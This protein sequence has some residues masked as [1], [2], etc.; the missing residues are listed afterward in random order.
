VI[1]VL[2]LALVAALAAAAAPP[3]ILLIVSD[4][5]G[6][7]DLGCCGRPELETPNLDR[8]IAEG[9]RATSFY[10]AWP[11]CTPSRGALLTGRYPQRNGLY[12][13]IR[14]DVADFG[15]T[16]TDAEYAVTPERILGLDVRETLI[17]EVLKKAGYATGVVGKWDSGQ[18]LRYLPLQRGFDFYYGFANTG[19]DYWTHERYEYP[20][21]RRGNDRIQEEG[22]ITDLFEREAVRFVDEH[23]DEPFFLYLPFNAPHGASNFDKPGAQGKPEDVAHYFAKQTVE[24]DT[25]A[26]YLAA[27]TAMDRA[28]GS[29]LER[30]ESHGILDETLI[31]FFSDNGG[32]G[33][34]DNTP[35]RGKKAQMWEGGLRVPFAA[36]WPEKI[37]AGRVTDEFLTALEVFPTLTA[38]AGAEL[39]EG[40]VYDGFDMLSVLAGDEPSSREEM[41]WERRGDRALRYR[42]WK[43]VDSRLGSGLFDLSVDIS[44]SNDLSDEMPERLR[45][46]QARFHD[47]KAR[48]EAAEPRGPFR[49]Y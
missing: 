15:V 43:W 46:M 44:E 21:L 20:S 33:R 39:P 42:Q 11:A 38:A 24:T 30:L 19:V 40:I 7:A 49:D 22:Y 32:S 26:H 27:I 5:Q 17:S 10:V 16:F 4:D 23:A 34:S 45:E 25:E 47:W 12:D 9:V 2:C 31:L 29:V 3:N 1:R 28:I 41:A 35:L 14:N 6:Y 36:R 48:M 18:L 37:P 13:M 8:I